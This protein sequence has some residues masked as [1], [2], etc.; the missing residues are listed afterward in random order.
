MVEARIQRGLLYDLGLRGQ[1]GDV[2]A[3]VHGS[4]LR[5]S[6]C[7]R[8]SICEHFESCYMGFFGHVHMHIGVFG[9]DCKPEQKASVDRVKLGKS[10]TERFP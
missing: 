5:L 2:R 7:H 4:N 9:V 6:S 8:A 3:A 10:E 1:H